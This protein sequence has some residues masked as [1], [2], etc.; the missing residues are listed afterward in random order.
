MMIDLFLISNYL[1]QLSHTWIFFKADQV[2]F[3]ALLFTIFIIESISNSLTGK[4]VYK[5]QLSGED[6]EFNISSL[7]NIRKNVIQADFTNEAYA[8]HN[9]HIFPHEPGIEKITSVK[10]T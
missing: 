7:R 8:L 6:H 5:H 9:E 2:E 1:S 10:Q 3:L 4:T